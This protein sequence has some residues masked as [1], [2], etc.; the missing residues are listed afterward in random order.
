ML[1]PLILLFPGSVEIDYNFSSKNIS[2][3][4]LQMSILSSYTIV[5][6][7]HFFQFC[8]FLFVPSVTYLFL[9]LDFLPKL[10]YLV[11]MRQLLQITINSTDKV[12]SPWHFVCA[13]Y[14][15]HLSF[16]RSLHFIF[17]LLK[18]HILTNI[19]IYKVATDFQ[20]PFK[21]P[22]SSYL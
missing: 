21:M 16:S 7:Y 12:F 6:H 2:Y 14:L 19:F 8:N 11:L 5:L 1:F 4:W 9:T 3:F 15:F 18:T 22:V 13:T 17:I 20:L 10:L